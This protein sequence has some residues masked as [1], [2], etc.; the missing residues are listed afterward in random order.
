MTLFWTWRSTSPKKSCNMRRLR[1]KQKKIDSRC[2]LSK[3]Q[4]PPKWSR[5]PSK[6]SW[7]TERGFNGDS[8]RLFSILNSLK[9]KNRWKILR[10]ANDYRRSWWRFRAHP[11]KLG[12]LPRGMRVVYLWL[13]FWKDQ[14]MPKTLKTSKSFSFSQPIPDQAT[15][16]SLAFKTGKC[17]ARQMETDV[18]ILFSHKTNRKLLVSSIWLSLTTNVWIWTLGGQSSTLNCIKLYKTSAG[19]WW[20]SKCL[21]HN[22]I[23]Y[24]S[25]ETVGHQ[26]HTELS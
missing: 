8:S 22:K 10:K 16:N 17:P 15:P 4:K 2:P 26:L 13:K 14:R 9:N 7:K 3:Y 20:G 19:S 21:V 6:L 5:T 12:F 24:W 11:N 25:A 23:S 1:L 18:L